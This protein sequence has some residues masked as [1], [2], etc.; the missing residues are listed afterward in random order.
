MVGLVIKPNLSDFNYLTISLLLGICKFLEGQSYYN[1]AITLLE[2]RLAAHQM[3]LTGNLSEQEHLSQERYS[4]GK[5][6]HGKWLKVFM[7]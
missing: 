6:E 1:I 7:S 4:L 3:I 2:M 5:N